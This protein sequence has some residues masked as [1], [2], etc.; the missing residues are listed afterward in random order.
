MSYE[1]AATLTMMVRPCLVVPMHYGMFAENTV[2]PQ[3]FVR[4]LKDR[5]PNARVAL[6]EYNRD[7]VCERVGGRVSLT[8]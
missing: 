3:L 4:A 8:P 2:D 5:A 1:D 7:Y 6:L